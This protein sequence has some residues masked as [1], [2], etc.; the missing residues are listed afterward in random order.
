MR[1]DGEIINANGCAMT[2]PQD[3]G[4]L[5]GGLGYRLGAGCL[6]IDQVNFI[7]RRTMDQARLGSTDRNENVAVLAAK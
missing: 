3:L 4:N 7:D 2:L 5:I 6:D 1:E